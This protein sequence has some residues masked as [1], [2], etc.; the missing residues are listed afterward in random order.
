MS[1]LRIEWMQEI[2]DMHTTYYSRSDL[3]QELEYQLTN[4][5]PTSFA[6]RHRNV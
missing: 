1:Y 6:D 2:K 3:A 5:V 4:L